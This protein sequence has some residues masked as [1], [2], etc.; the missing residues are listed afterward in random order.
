M[1]DVLTQVTMVD[2]LVDALK[3]HD[4]Y[5]QHLVACAL[6]RWLSASLPSTAKNVQSAT[7]SALR[8]ESVID[9]TA[10]CTPRNGRTARNTCTY[11]EH[12]GTARTRNHTVRKESPES[13]SSSGSATAKEISTRGEPKDDRSPSGTTSKSTGT[14][15]TRPVVRVDADAVLRMTGARDAEKHS[16]VHA[17]V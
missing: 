16:K 7:I 8:N 3:S 4:G 9:E 12:K 17:Q 15:N 2:S 14:N 11:V 13:P 1:A 5:K 10:P 6:H